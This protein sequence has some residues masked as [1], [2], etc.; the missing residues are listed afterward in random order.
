MPGLI[1]S[2]PWKGAENAR[3]KCLEWEGAFCYKAMPMKMRMT[4][5]LISLVSFLLLFSGSEIAQAQ[6]HF[7]FSFSVVLGDWQWARGGS[8]SSSAMRGRL[9]RHHFSRERPSQQGWERIQLGYA[10]ACHQDF[11]FRSSWPSRD[12]GLRLPIQGEVP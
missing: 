8:I 1:L 10:G 4:I 12:P 2:R 7:Y 9:L 5:L 6:D 11:R 3:R